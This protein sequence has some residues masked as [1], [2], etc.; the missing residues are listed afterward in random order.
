MISDQNLHG[1][2]HAP[3]SCVRLLD[4][5]LLWPHAGR[6]QQ[7]ADCAGRSLTNRPQGLWCKLVLSPFSLPLW[8]YLLAYHQAMTMVH[9]CDL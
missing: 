9:D 5:D 3:A 4:S 6:T 8:I 7:A 2:S 1:E